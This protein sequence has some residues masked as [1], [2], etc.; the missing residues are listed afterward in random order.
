MLRDGAT[1]YSNRLMHAY[2]QK[3]RILATAEGREE[4]LH[5]YSQSS[6]K[7]RFYRTLC[8]VRFGYLSFLVVMMVL[9]FSFTLLMEFYLAIFL[10]SAKY[11]EYYTVRAVVSLILLPVS[12]GSLP[13]FRLA[14]AVVIHYLRHRTE[15]LRRSRTSI[16]PGGLLKAR[17]SLLLTAKNDPFLDDDKEEEDEAWDRWKRIQA[18]VKTTLLIKK[19]QDEG[20][21]IDLSTFLVVDFVCP[22]FFEI[23]TAASMV[24]KWVSGVLEGI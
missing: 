18:A 3:D 7:W 9:M 16:I 12:D 13:N 8:Q 24:I 14:L 20:P 10:P 2:K 15:L 6:G 11:D 1:G 17:G 22:V 19:V 4:E 21:A 23:F 5:A